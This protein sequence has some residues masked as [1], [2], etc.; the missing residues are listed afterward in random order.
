MTSYVRYAK[1]DEAEIAIRSIMSELRVQVLPFFNC[2]VYL[3]QYRVLL[4]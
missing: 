3:S 1:N 2:F 4:I